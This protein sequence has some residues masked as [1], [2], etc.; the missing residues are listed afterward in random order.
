MTANYDLVIR[1][2]TIVDGSGSEP[3]RAD[4]AITDG[5]IESIG[6]VNE[7]GSEEIDADGCVVTPGFIEGHTH[8]D[9][10]VMWDPLGTPSCWHGVTTVV[11]GNCGFT[12]AP[13]RFDQR[14][15]ILRNL[16]RAEDIPRYVIESAVEWTWETFADYLDVV[17]RLPKGIN[18][19]ANIGHSALRTWAMGERAFEESATEEDLLVMESELRDALASWGNRLYD[20]TKPGSHDNGWRSGRVEAGDLERVP[21]ARRCDGI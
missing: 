18:Y 4:V 8:L 16:E 11:M 1:G 3:Y 20:L 6:R 7:P 17:D 21:A 19:I 12:L 13:G 2:G 9:A 10:Q 15:A 5:R 14:E